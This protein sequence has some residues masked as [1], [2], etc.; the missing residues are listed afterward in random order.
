MKVCKCLVLILCTIVAHAAD[1]KEPFRPAPIEN[2]ASKQTNEKLTVAAVAFDN[3][4]DA[5][6]A[7]G[8]VNPYEFGMLPVLLLLKNEGPKTL[9]LES[10]Q[11][12][13]VTPNNRHVE[14]TP[15]PEVPY[16]FNR[17]AKVEPR[18][19]PTGG[20]QIKMKK[21]PLTADEIQNRAFAAKML[22]PGDSAFGFFYFQ[23]GFSRGARLYLNGIKEAGSNR[24][25]FYFEISLG[26]K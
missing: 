22:P 7:F 4:D 26:D 13:Y 1:K 16:A 17:Q 14:A 3:A 12:E 2:Y 19:F 10:M 11:V 24:E 15:A 20:P 18:K 9:S 8:K 6:Q 21:N 5:H 23:T 25:L